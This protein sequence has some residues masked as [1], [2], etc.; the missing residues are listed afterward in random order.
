[1]LL[2]LPVVVHAQYTGGKGSGDVS[3]AHSFTL[4][5]NDFKDQRLSMI[6]YPNPTIEFM[7]LKIETDK[8]ET[9]SYQVYDFNGKLL[10]IQ[11]INSKET[12]IPM[13]DLPDAIY[14]LKVTDHNKTLKT[15]RIIK[16]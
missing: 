9:L 11:K 13:Q 5:I 1:M 16:N 14:F 4:G 15:F 3:F 6:V 10:Y 8:F 7:K 12:S 2:A